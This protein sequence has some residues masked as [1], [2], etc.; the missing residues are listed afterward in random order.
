MR[1]KRSLLVATAAVAAAL[2]ILLLSGCGNGYGDNGADTGAATTAETTTETA[3]APGG[4][5]TQL[6]G[7]VGPGFTITLTRAGEAVETLEAGSYEI[8]IEDRSASHNFHLT[9]PGIDEATEVPESGTVVWNLD[10]AA[11]SYT[12]VCDPHAA[13]MRGSFEVT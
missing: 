2:S 3:P 7:T 13:T 8:T 11:G 1:S 5:A 10:L 4:N 9:G 6:T 12:Y